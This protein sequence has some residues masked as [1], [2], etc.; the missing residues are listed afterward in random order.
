MHQPVM[1]IARRELKRKD[2]EMGME[3]GIPFMFVQGNSLPG[4]RSEKPNPEAKW[5]RINI[6]L[7]VDDT[8]VVGRRTELEEGLKITKET[9]SKFEEK[10]NDY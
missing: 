6:S 10:N 1:R 5:V 7:F 8:A 2:D 4:Q 3:I 9:M